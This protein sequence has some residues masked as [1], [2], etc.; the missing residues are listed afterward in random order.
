MMKKN[1]LI[2][3]LVL[4]AALL[5]AALFTTCQD[6][7]Q[8]ADKKIF[9]NDLSQSE[10]DELGKTIKNDQMDVRKLV[11]VLP[12]ERQVAWQE[13]GFT[14]F[15]HFGPNTFWTG[16]GKTGQE[17][18]DGTEPVT[19]FAPTQLNTDQWIETLKAA[20][21]KAAIFTA[22]HHDGFCLWDTQ[23]TYHSVMN[24]GHNSRTKTKDPDGALTGTARPDAQK[25]D[26]VDLFV[27]SC[28]KYGL[29]AGIYL[30]PWDRN[31]GRYGVYGNGPKPDPRVSQANLNLGYG[32]I[33][34]WSNNPAGKEYND[35]T[36]FYI[37]QLT[38][39]LD[40]RYGEIYSMW[41]DGAGSGNHDDDF[42]S[43]KANLYGNQTYNWARIFAKVRE[44]QP[45]CVLTNVG[46]DAAWIGNESAAVLPSHW[47][48]APASQ[49]Y[50]TYIIS[51]S[52]QSVGAP[53]VT[54]KTD[55]HTG[56]RDNLKDQVDLIWNPLEADVS[57]R[58]GWFFHSSESSK[59]VDMLLAIYERCVGGNV[60]LLLNIPPDKT[61]NIHTDTDAAKNDVQILKDLGTKIKG[62]YGTDAFP[63]GIFA[64][65]AYANPADFTAA[66]DTNL[67]L[68]V[69]VTIAVSG[70]ED[71]PAHPITN[72][73][74]NDDTYWRPK[75]EQQYHT[76]TGGGNPKYYPITITI[77]LPKAKALT[78]VMLQE[79]IRLSQRIERFS[80][81]VSSN[82]SSW[83]TVYAPEMMHGSVSVDRNVGFKRI[84]HF[85]KESTVKYIQIKIYDSRIY[86]T[87]KYVAA[88]CEP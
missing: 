29:K 67:R 6:A 69:G 2:A 1:N 52:Q 45:N 60:Q 75:G 38:E 13:L 36:D 41:M 22:K 11:Q 30:S 82:K 85:P 86:P 14:A 58:P 47:S 51:Q 24:D 50:A 72:I 79:N 54:S 18:G 39:L 31:Q 61:G 55:P 9:E 15:I 63:A 35:Y 27:K 56:T 33:K 57:N 17:W 81:S 25:V 68:G 32:G 83:K 53:P 34:P 3:R 76:L 10:Q 26:I 20:G 23:T 40:G 62:I 87:L 65:P 48:V 80:V 46:S 5:C 84:C 21:F 66:A 71:D 7:V 49:A 43:D 70:A 74:T 64:N 59:S 28:A 77:T 8:G 12:H 73:L 78:H 44:L 37:D 19:T 42:R 4:P 88:Y 16:D